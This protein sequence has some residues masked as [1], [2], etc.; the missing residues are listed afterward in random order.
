MATDPAPPLPTEPGSTGALTAGTD[1]GRFRIESLVGQGGMGAVYLAWDPVLERRVALKAIRLGNEGRLTSLERFRR[2]AMAL[3]QVN[4]RHVCQIHDWVEH[5]GSAYIAME[6][7]EGE[8]LATAGRQ[9]VLPQKLLAIRAIALALEAAHAKGI[10]HRD[11][12]ASNVMVDGQGQV[13]VLD[14]GL[15]RLLDA[16]QL[17]GDCT[18]GEVPP[19]PRLPPAA[20]HDFTL[21][22]APLLA[23]GDETSIGR[24]SCASSPESDHR[25]DMTEAGTFMGSPAYASPEQ[26]R[27]KRVGPPSDVFSLGVLA[28]ELIL[29]EHPYAGEG[30]VRMLAMVQGEPRSL[31][32]RH[33]PRRVSR[34]L[35]A[36]LRRDPAAR[37][38][39]QAVAGALSRH[40]DRTPAIGWV[41]GGTA[42]LLG[43]LYIGYLLL[44]RSI[45]A[46]FAKEHPPR[47]AVLP[48]RNA[49][50]EA[51]LDAQVSL[52]MAELFSSA[53]RSSPSLSV[54]EPEAIARATSGL[55][56]TAAEAQEPAGQMRLAKA[57]GAQLLMRGVLDADAARQAR[58]LRYELVDEAGETRFSGQVRA[59]QGTFDP[60]A[61]VDPAAHA[62][63]RKVDP[64]R[65]VAAQGIP[66]PQGAFAAY[67]NGKALLQK[68]DFKASEAELREAAMRAP[69]FAPAVLAYAS[70][71][72]RLGREQALATANWAL[73]SAKAAG[74]RWT[75]GRALGLKA[76]LAKDQG[77]LGEAQAL[78]ERELGLAQALGDHDSV[79]VTLNHLGLI[80]QERGQEAE[81]LRFH[82][83]SLDLSRRIGDQVYLSLAQ[84]N[85]ANLALK[86]GDLGAAEGLYRN[87]LALQQALGN[88]WGEALALNN[89][90]VV[91]L[92]GRELAKAEGLLSRAL[93]IRMAV[94]D[95]EG[96][97]T[98]LRNLGILALLK[99][100]A[101]RSADFHG[102]A[103]VLAKE[104]GHRTLE[105][106]CQF[107]VADLIRRQGQFPPARA[108][109]ERV[110]QL[111]P[112]GVTPGVRANALAALAECRLRLP[113]H[114]VKE[115][116]RLLGSLP[117]AHTDSPFV[118]R[119]KA[120]LAYQ[121]GH[122]PEA[123]AELE[124]ALADP[125]R[126]APELRHE[127]EQTRARFQAGSAHSAK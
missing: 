61:L 89:L 75:E 31:R 98:C 92:A 95:R 119:A 72:R 90:G 120:W 121:T 125:K 71:L 27:G 37:P 69:A 114:E 36:M 5:E 83:Q 1:I 96:Q 8:T 81:A 88:R 107:Y 122:G 113:A 42:A 56:M 110:L 59:T 23:Q 99:G 50:G 2:E 43:L 9:M 54:V 116:E 30:Q 103:L 25:G 102:Q 124:W 55:R 53:L 79:A 115:A 21:A 48:L 44:G 93:G 49:T 11:L 112:E 28:W 91:A 33:L 18:T 106:E 104:M 45:I 52:G 22:D 14:F 126:Q 41:G 123:L 94:G 66:L 109:Y 46:D 117:A 38:S 13:K 12:K 60:Y 70:C 4:H 97:I 64:M 77:D 82:Q 63:L 10:V 34:L 87:N 74:D 127:L 67:A 19:L 78:R 57:L 80:A 26:L 100:D 15:A 35:R 17:Q 86:G 40:L 20:G 39:A 6:Y 105:A 62:L 101:A 24:L 76:Y 111:L 3:A 65:G 58:V 108:G 16:A 29:A 85:L 47:L 51:R 118:H 7:I 73:M 84:N 68:G 32:G